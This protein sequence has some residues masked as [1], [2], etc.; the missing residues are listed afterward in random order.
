MRKRIKVTGF[1]DWDTMF[2]NNL[3]SIPV[4]A[5]ASIVAENWGYE[6]LNLNLWVRNGSERRA[7]LTCMMSVQPPCYAQFPAV[8]HR[9]FW[10]GCCRNIVY[11]CMVHPS[12]KQY[13]L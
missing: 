4:L 10:R 1:S 8:R 9:V 2:Y 5:V 7:L 13:H 12:N 11:D 3:L 6:N